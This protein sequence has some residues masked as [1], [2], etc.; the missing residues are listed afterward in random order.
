MPPYLHGPN[1]NGRR[2]ANPVLVLVEQAAQCV[3]RFQCGFR[4][5]VIRIDG[6]QRRAQDVF[7]GGGAWRLSRREQG[8]L[9]L[10]RGSLAPA[11]QRALAVALGLE[12][13]EI[14][15]RL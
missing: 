1:L 13:L 3:E 4:R 2:P 8:Q 7:S 10:R 11:A 14:T 9:A 12:R 6:P 15:P 5:K